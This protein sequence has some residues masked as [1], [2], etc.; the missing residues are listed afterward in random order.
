MFKKTMKTLTT[1]QKSGCGKNVIQ[2]HG[3][4]PLGINLKD[5]QESLEVATTV[6]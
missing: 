6:V 1:E 2:K 4:D 5:S 3:D